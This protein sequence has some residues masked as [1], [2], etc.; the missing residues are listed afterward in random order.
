[1]IAMLCMVSFFT[2]SFRNQ[3][4]R[5]ECGTSLQ[6]YSEARAYIFVPTTRKAEVIERH[7]S[8]TDKSTVR[9]PDFVVVH[10]LVTH[11]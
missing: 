9:A 2:E 4:Q 3:D 11:S 7:H 1:M 8:E 10:T 6:W 5:R